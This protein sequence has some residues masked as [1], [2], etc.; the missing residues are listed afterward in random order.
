[1]SVDGGMVWKRSELCFDFLITLFRTFTQMHRSLF[2]SKTLQA[3]Y[4]GSIDSLTIRG[5]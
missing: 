5:V 3:A 2:L 1:M 4:V